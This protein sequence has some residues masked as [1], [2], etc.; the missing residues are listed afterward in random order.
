MSRPSW[1]RMG[2]ELWIRDP[3]YQINAD[4]GP[5]NRSPTRLGTGRQDRYQLEEIW[6]RIRVQAHVQI[7][8]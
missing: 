7:H 6:L 1:I 3:A 2:S 4:P 8:I 5:Q